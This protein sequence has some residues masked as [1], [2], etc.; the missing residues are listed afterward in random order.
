MTERRLRACDFVSERSPRVFGES[1][2]VSFGR[3][4]LVYS[5]ARIGAALSMKVEDVYVQNR[6]LWVR[7]HEK[8]GKRPEM[9]CR[10]NLESYL[11][12]YM[13]SSWSLPEILR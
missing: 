7:L 1:G 4:L 6:R 11:H 10:H 13:G 3:T 2:N 12:A 5:F 8:G 9:P